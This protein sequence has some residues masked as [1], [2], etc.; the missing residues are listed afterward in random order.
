ME[1][2]FL[3]EMPYPNF[4]SCRIKNPKLFKPSS[5]RT[6]H[7][8]TKGLTF[9]SGNLKSTGKSAVQSFRYDKKIWNKSR[10]SSHCSARNGKFEAAVKKMQIFNFKKEAVDFDIRNNRIKDL[11]RDAICLKEIWHFLQTSE[12]FKGWK[13]EDVLEY[14]E[15][16][17]KVLKEKEYPLL[18]K[19]DLVP[20]D[21]PE[22]LKPGANPLFHSSASPDFVYKLCLLDQEEKGVS[23]S[24]AK[25]ICSSFKKT[26]D[27]KKKD[28]SFYLDVPKKNMKFVYH[29]RWAGLTEDEA[30]T[31]YE[32][33]MDESKDLKGV[34]RFSMNDHLV[35]Y[36]IFLGEA[37]DN[38]IDDSF[39]DL[40][41][42][43]KLKAE[44]K[45]PQPKK[46]LKKEGTHSLEE[47]EL[48]SKDWSRF[49]IVDK[50]KYKQGVKREHFHEY[51]LEGEK[52]NGRYIFMY[53]PA[54]KAKKKITDTEMDK[55]FLED[56]K[57]EDCEERVWLVQKPKNQKPYAETHDLNNVIAELK[58]KNQKWLVWSSPNIKAEK[59]NIEECKKK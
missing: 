14:H 27:E 51:F 3:T 22:L 56:I 30:N 21:I 41:G 49:F 26:K 1:T 37:K 43:E 28:N 29:H 9:I 39:I 5:F 52:L 32:K 45:L 46:W 12:E 18:I 57:N 35:G 42:K 11:V 47:M 58:S 48:N 24:A 16:V 34:L 33:D 54:A 36:T 31:V 13:K 19:K 50:G 10:A 2:V 23:V 40:T 6:L 53:V 55:I 8:K 25:K 38:I 59:I 20:S 44:L 4:H 7:T 15:K 17:I